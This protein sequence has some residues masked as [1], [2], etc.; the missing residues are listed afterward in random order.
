MISARQVAT[1]VG[2]FDRSPAYAGLA[3]AL[4]TAIGDGRI[5]LQS[6][7][8]SERDL[9]DVLS[10]SRTTVTRAYAEL[11]E[12]GY[13][14]ARRGAGTFTRVPHGRE[15][16]HDRLVA[17]Y[18]PTGNTVDLVCAAGAAPPGVL[19]AYQ[20]ALDDLP[21]HLG[22]HGYFPTGLPALREVIAAC[23]DAQGLPTDPD[24]V[25]ITPGAQSAGAI[26]AMALLS[27]GERA[28]VETPV[29][30]N[31]PQVLRRAGARLV[32]LP[33]GPAGWDL[34]SAAATVRQ[35][36]P[37]VAYLI[38]DFQN[39]T[40]ALMSDAD[41]AGMADLLARTRTVPV[42]D[43][44]ERAL[45]LDD[46]AMPL[47]F[48][49]YS[50]DTVSLGSASKTFWGGLRV[51]WIRAPH[52]LVPRL[53]QARLSLD[54][55]VAVLEQLT[56]TR[57]LS[58]P[59]PLLAVQRNRLR[60]QR[61]HLVALLGDQLPQWRFTVP[62]GGLVLWCEL[63]APAAVAV[64]AEAERRGAPVAPGP[65]FAVEGG[66]GR[67]IRIPWTR[68]VEDLST[69]VAR[70]AEAWSHAG[71]VEHATALPGTDGRVMVA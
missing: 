61:D 37:A 18:D 24:Q 40:G 10:V 47:P 63:P 7:L 43:E 70:I 48:A 66:L 15:R 33:L 31:T 25:I 27:A 67:H 45:L 68:S 16:A 19:A 51:G 21:A 42:I 54:L 8:P 12:A 46:R 69:G 13:A 34:E 30:P 53:I 50:A 26:T 9:T 14:E 5:A 49:A 3:D 39:P 41:R 4:R 17:P 65:T 55:G 64:A 36:A 59:E 35:T 71:H 32:P 6:R 1:V 52:H 22:N 11:R 29:Y 60:T 38:P 2:D 57:I 44:A 23:Y 28:L 58:D 56:L 62:A 20:A